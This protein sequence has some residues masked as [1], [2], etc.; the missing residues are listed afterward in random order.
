MFL[1]LC[2]FWQIIIFMISF[3]QAVLIK[4][5]ISTF[6]ILLFQVIKWPYNIWESGYGYW[7]IPVTQW[8]LKRMSRS[9]SL[10]ILLQFLLV[11]N[12]GPKSSQIS[13]CLFNFVK[14]NS[15]LCNKLGCLL[16]FEDFPSDTVHRSVYIFIFH[17]CMS[18]I[19]AYPWKPLQAKNK[20]YIC[21]SQAQL[22]T[23]CLTKHTHTHT[24]LFLE[25]GL[26][27]H[28]SSLPLAAPPSPAI[29]VSCFSP[30]PSS[31][32]SSLL[33][34]ALIPSLSSLLQGSHPSVML[35][36]WLTHK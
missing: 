19:R 8:L 26:T 9:Y 31:L 33:C 11:T 6:F 34:L 27:F 35:S 30:H 3:M 24:F 16:S 2:L 14:Q 17:I 18:P 21:Y 7:S 5:A 32:L 20:M 23:Q 4:R 10:S 36:Y 22:H 1:G 28:P 29:L 25:A 13:K 15:V 12:R